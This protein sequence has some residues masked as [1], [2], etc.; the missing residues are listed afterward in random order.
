MNNMCYDVPERGG[1]T[2]R[3]INEYRQ[4]KRQQFGTSPSH[5]TNLYDVHVYRSL[6]NGICDIAALMPCC[7]LDAQKL[8]KGHRLRQQF[9]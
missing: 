1:D 3:L 2:Q 4:R 9:W 5:L 7:K 8:I 6:L